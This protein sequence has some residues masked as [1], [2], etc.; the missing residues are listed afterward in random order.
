[1][2]KSSK[3]LRSRTRGT[4]TKEVR[5]RGLPPVTRFLREFPIGSKVVVRIEASEPRGLPHPRYQG[6][7]CTVVGRVGRAYRL[8][9]LDGG[10]P[11][12]LIAHAVHL[13]PAGGA[14]A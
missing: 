1:M 3:G 13:A 12:Q 11:K 10:K 4:L 9:F 5:E 2:V 14:D 7:T 6:R 8:A